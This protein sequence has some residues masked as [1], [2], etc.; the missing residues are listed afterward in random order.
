MARW[1]SVEHA[2]K[3]PGSGY[4]FEL[5]FAAL[6]WK[7]ISEPARRSATVRETRTSPAPASDETPFRGVDGDTE[8]CVSSEFD[9]TVVEPRRAPRPRS[10]WTAS[11]NTSHAQRIT[12]GSVE[13]REDTV[14]GELHDSSSEAIKF[15]GDGRIMG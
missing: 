6:Q 15:F 11:R 14:A 4:A 8:T 1:R 9:F 12:C 13:G 5:M 2:V 10:A 7:A 3:P